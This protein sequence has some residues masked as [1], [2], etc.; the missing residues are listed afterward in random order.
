[1]QRKSP[2]LP[3][4]LVPQSSSSQASDCLHGEHFATRLLTHGYPVR[5]RV[6]LQLLQRS[7]LFIVQRQVQM[8]T[9]LISAQPSLAGRPR[10]SRYRGNPL[11]D[12]RDQR[13]ELFGRGGIDPMKS[14]FSI[15]LGREDAIK[16]QHVK[17]QGGNA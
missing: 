13:V 5:D 6:A 10:R 8:I 17:M 15:A 3:S 16:K 14:Q 9:S 12:R 4:W 7:T 2:T 1:M 11:A